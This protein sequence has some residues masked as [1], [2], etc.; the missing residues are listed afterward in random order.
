M[1]QIA[2][3]SGFTGR[4]AKQTN[5]RALNIFLKVPSVRGVCWPHSRH[6]M[7]LPGALDLNGVPEGLAL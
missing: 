5:C 4:Q 7:L 2:G 1:Y 3:E 6:D